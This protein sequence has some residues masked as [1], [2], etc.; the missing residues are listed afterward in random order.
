MNRLVELYF[1]KSE[2]ERYI[3]LPDPERAQAFYSAWTRKEAYLK[4]I[5]AGLQH[6]PDHV[7]VSL[8]PDETFPELTLLGHDHPEI[9]HHLFSFQPAEGYQASVAFTGEVRD[10]IAINY[11]HSI[12]KPHS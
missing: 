4:S 6:P 3:S 8:D 2:N 5:G 1:S 10:V 9:T 11:F 7:V 12:T